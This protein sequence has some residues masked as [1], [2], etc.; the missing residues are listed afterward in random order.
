[1]TEGGLYTVRWA[2]DRDPWTNEE[3]VSLDT[4]IVRGDAPESGAILDLVPWMSTMGH[5]IDGAVEIT[6]LEPGTYRSSWTFTMPGP[7][8]VR[9]DIDGSGGSDHLVLTTHVQ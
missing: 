3:P 4:Q 7:W 5:G 1:M 8:D 2:P 9:I 6:E